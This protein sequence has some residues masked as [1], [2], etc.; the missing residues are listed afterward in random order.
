MLLTKLSRPIDIFNIE[1]WGVDLNGLLQEIRNQYDDYEWDNY[2]FRQNQIEFFKAHLPVDIAENIENSFWMNY[3]AGKINEVE[4]EQLLKSV[5]PDKLEQFQQIKPTRKR[6][7]SE[8]NLFFKDDWE[9]KRIPAR[10]FGQEYALTNNSDSPDYR[11]T[12]RQFKEM[13]NSLNSKNLRLTLLGI[14]DELKDK[15]PSIM[16]LNIIVHHT[17]VYCYSDQLATTSPEGI[18][19]DGMD[20]IVSALVMER[21]NILGGRSVV[22]GNDSRTKI[23]ETTLQSG[24]GIL[25]PDLGTELWHEVTA[26]KCV[27]PSKPGYRS[28]IGYDITVLKN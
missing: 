15:D 19:Q 8:F 22:Y 6:L 13:P 23:M 25:Q 2:L 14:A 1:E 26:I 10:I 17:L 28:T 3:Y 24:Q 18:H 4:I 16:G 21:H 20:Y 5:S 7:I 27:D 12:Q 9:I 11:L